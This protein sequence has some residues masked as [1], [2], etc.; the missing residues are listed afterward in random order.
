MPQPGIQTIL[1]SMAWLC[2][3]KGITSLLAQWILS[4]PWDFELFPSLVFSVNP[5]GVLFRRA[6][7][8]SFQPTPLGN[9][10]F[11]S[12]STFLQNS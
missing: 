2:F 8:H 7:S 12:A 1:S 3:S 5:R 10:T 6:V 9:I 11:V 4:S